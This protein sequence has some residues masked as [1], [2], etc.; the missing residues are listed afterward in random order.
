VAADPPRAPGLDVP[1]GFDGIAYYRWHGSPRQYFSAYGGVELDRL[2]SAILQ[3]KQQVWCV[4][5]NTGS[6]AAAANALDLAGR[7]RA[8]DANGSAAASSG[9][10]RRTR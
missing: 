3:R 4:F 6:G 8:A 9:I 1:G 7:L 2:A 5:D 10:G